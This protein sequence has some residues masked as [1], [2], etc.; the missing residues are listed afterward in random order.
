MSPFEKYLLQDKANG[1]SH[2]I[3]CLRN[4]PSGNMAWELIERFE[5]SDWKVKPK[6]LPD[7][8]AGVWD[9]L[10]AESESPKGEG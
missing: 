3:N 6:D 10:K 2:L 7:F 5:G 9:K 8:L 4:G 1:V